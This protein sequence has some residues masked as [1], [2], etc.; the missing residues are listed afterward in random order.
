MEG[1]AHILVFDVVEAG[2]FDFEPLGG[3]GPSFAPDRVLHGLAEGAAG[4]RG[5]VV[6][7]FLKCA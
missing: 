1:N 2:A 3:R 6:E 4:V 7:D 5:R